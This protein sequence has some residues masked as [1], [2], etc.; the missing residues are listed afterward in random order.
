MA[1]EQGYQGDRKDLDKKPYGRTFVVGRD[2]KMTIKNARK[3]NIREKRFEQSLIRDNEGNVWGLS[4]TA[5]YAPINQQK[6]DIVKEEEKEYINRV[7][8]RFKK[9]KL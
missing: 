6:L 1:K 7:N 5:S 3:N 2:S 9:A 4:A 8:K